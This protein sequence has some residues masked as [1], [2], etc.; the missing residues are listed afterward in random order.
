MEYQTYDAGICIMTKVLSLMSGR[1]KPIILYLIRSD[2]NRFSMMQ[3]AMPKISKK[4]LTEQLRELEND[5]LISRTVEGNKAPYVVTYALTDQG[6]SL[7]TLID[8]MIEWG[9]KHF[10]NDYSEMLMEEFK[11]KSP[12]NLIQVSKY[13]AQI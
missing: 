4:I 9:I 13:K 11:L 3:R 10:K 8:S 2:I 1:W 7:R 12:V 5:G 6:A